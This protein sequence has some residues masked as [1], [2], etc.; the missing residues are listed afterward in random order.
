MRKKEKS[1]VKADEAI[2][3]IHQILKPLRASLDQLPENLGSV[4]NPSDPARASS[5]L[6]TEIN[7]IYTDLTKKLIQSKVIT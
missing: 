5:I 1:L 4:L 7:N 2:E 3:V 6:E